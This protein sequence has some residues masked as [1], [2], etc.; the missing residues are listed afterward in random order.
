MT[1]AS[2]TDL[3]IGIPLAPGLPAERA[4]SARRSAFLH[5]RGAAGIILVAVVF[6]IGLA[7]PLITRYDPTAQLTN[8]NLLHADTVHYFGTDQVNR[9]I[10]ARAVYGIRVDILVSLIAVPIG[11]VTGSL[12]GLLS[13]VAGPADVAVQRL[14]DVLLSFPAIILAIGLTAV[15]GSGIRT[16]V[17]VIAVVEI[18]IFGRLVRSSVLRIRELPYVAAAEV[19][20]AGRLSILRRHVLPNA[21]EPLVVQLALSMS[22]AVFLES[23]MSFLG[24]GV[25]PPRPSLGSVISDSLAY[26][27][28]NPLFALGP[29][30]FVAML[31]L[32]FQLIAQAIG[33]GRRV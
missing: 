12:I 26:L 1:D 13:T 31:V 30:L 27:D 6:G 33:A 29:L 22:V 28:Y 3:A 11:A 7:A 14:F 5:G 9:D 2:S 21:A 10:F 18:P 17:I 32:G 24:I 4:R 25:R 23:A 19:I 8:A 16:V 20:G 15:L